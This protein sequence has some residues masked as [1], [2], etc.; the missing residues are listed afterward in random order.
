MSK[1]MS[2]VLE[3][4][5]VIF[6]NKV[7]SAFFQIFCALKTIYVTYVTYGARTVMKRRKLPVARSLPECA[8]EAAVC[9]RAR[10]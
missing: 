5:R 4:L 7:F 6:Y 3:T 10:A 8:R 9:G 2:K 1:R